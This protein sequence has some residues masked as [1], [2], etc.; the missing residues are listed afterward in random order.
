M[1]Q[2]LVERF[3]RSPPTLRDLCVSLDHLARLAHARENWQSAQEACQESLAIRRHLVEWLGQTPATLRDLT[4]ALNN[5]GRVAQAQQHWD[6][7][8]SAYEESLAIHQRLMNRPIGFMEAADIAKS[9]CDLGHLAAAQ[10]NWGDAETAYRKSVEFHRRFLVHYAEMPEA[11]DK[12]GAAL[13]CLGI[14]QRKADPALFGETA[15]VYANLVDKCPL[16]VAYR[17][18][19]HYVTTEWPRACQ[20]GHGAQAAPTCDLPY[21]APSAPAATFRSE[22]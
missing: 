10:N 16:V 21:P 15:S 18:R 1:R 13:I 4:V 6:E 12:F 7:A 22:S 11:L 17:E 8:R 3:Q 9:F 19:L 5:M 20:A 14:A 2:T